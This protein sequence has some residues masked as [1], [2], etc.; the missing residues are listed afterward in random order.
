MLT[1][2]AQDTP[3]EYVG[4]AVHTTTSLRFRNWCA[5]HTLPRPYSSV[6]CP[7]FLRREYTKKLEMP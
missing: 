1:G 2:R 6:I 4:C 3:G 7:A 5:Q